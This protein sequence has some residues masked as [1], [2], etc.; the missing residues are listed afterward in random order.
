MSIQEQLIVANTRIAELDA[1]LGKRPC[2]N[3]RCAELEASRALLREVGG[4]DPSLMPCTMSP[5]LAQRIRSYLDA[6][7]TLAEREKP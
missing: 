2:Q 1:Q 4:K 6:C 7:D 3:N 5:M